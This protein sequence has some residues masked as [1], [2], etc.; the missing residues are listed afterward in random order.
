MTIHSG[1]ST[2]VASLR[3]DAIKEYLS[4]HGWVQKPFARPAVLYF[5]GPR[6]DHGNPIVQILPDS[7]QAADFPL[8]VHDLLA[9]LSFVEQRPV[10]HILHELVGEAAAAPLRL[11]NRRAEAVRLFV[12]PRGGDR[13]LSPG[14]TVELAFSGPPRE[15]E[16]EIGSDFAALHAPR[17]SGS[18]LLSSVSPARRSPSDVV[19]D[20]LERFPAV[21]LSEAGKPALSERL[22][23]ADA[24]FGQ[25]EPSAE[26]KVACLY[27]GELVETLRGHLAGDE[28]T[29]RYVIWRICANLLSL[30]DARLELST[31][32]MDH[33]ARL[34]ASG[35]DLGLW[36]YDLTPRGRRNDAAV[37]QER[38]L[39]HSRSPP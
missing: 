26:P 30:I 22:A 5:E 37:V 3:L 2:A 31:A 10:E 19:R 12:A 34:S 16:I 20:E 24:V 9:S 35:V 38:P 33:V 21:G 18:V 27:A 29:R 28:A 32:D 11:T 15:I 23:V 39:G 13:L 17:E 25:R 1:L 8:R 7:E 6:D 14:E 4:R 36:L